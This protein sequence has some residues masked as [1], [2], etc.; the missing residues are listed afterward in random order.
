MAGR[1]PPIKDIDMTIQRIVVAMLIAAAGFSGA[2]PTFA[3][4]TAK[5]RYK[6]ADEAADATYMADREK[7]YVLSGNGKQVCIKQAKAAREHSKQDAKA[8]Y[9]NTPKALASA[10]KSEADADY[11]VAREK[12]DALA[13]DAK[14]VC[15][16]QAKAGQA[17]AV[18]HADTQLELA[19]TRADARAERAGARY[20]VALVKCDAL[21]GTAKDDCV[22]AAKDELKK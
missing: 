18:A 2:P 10:R 12:C 3:A 15:V 21:A 7:C 16:K 6:S 11:A 9:K 5:A 22:S 20:K 14:E 8:E 13:A 1:Q 4:D 19:K 17:N